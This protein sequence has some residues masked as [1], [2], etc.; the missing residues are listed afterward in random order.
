MFF[1]FLEHAGTPHEGHIPHSGRYPWMSGEKW[2]KRPG[3]WVKN[4][5]AQE[6]YFREHP[7][8]LQDEK[9]QKNYGI[10][11]EDSVEVATAKLMNMKTD[12]YRAYKS[13]RKQEQKLIDIPKAVEMQAK[14]ASVADIAKELDLP[15]STVKTYLKPGALAAASPTYTIANGLLQELEKRKYL[16]VGLGVERQLGISKEQLHKALLMLQDDGYNWFTEENDNAIL[17]KQAQNPSKKTTFSVLTG[18]DVTKEELWE[19][20]EQISSPDGIRFEDYGSELV[21]RGPVESIDSDRVYIRYDEEGGTNKEGV[22]EIRPG[23]EDLSLGGRTYAQVRIAVDGTHYLKGMAVYGYD[24]PEGYDIVFNTN[25][26]EG[27]PALGPSGNTVLKLMSDDPNNPFGSNTTQWDYINSEGIKTQS[28]IEI[29]N[30]DKDWEKW[31]KSLPSQVLSK[32]PIDLAKRQLN[33]A[34]LKK[35]Q[36]FEE[37]MSINNPT[38]RKQL[39][40]EFA[41]SCDSD[42][43]ELKAAALPGQSTKVLLP[44]TSLK[45][46]EVYCP[47]YDQGTEVILIRFPHAGTFEIPTLR[48]NNDNEEAKTVLGTHPAHAIG[49][50]TAVTSVL[51]GADFDGDT[52]LIIPTANQ[53]IRTTPPLEGLKNFDP[54]AKYKKTADQQKTGDGDGFIKGRTM[55]DITNLITDMT[56]MA[57]SKEGGLNENDLS[58]IERAVRHSMVVI[59]AEKHNLDWKQS[60]EDNKIAELKI[61]YQGGVRRGAA[62]LISRAGGEGSIDEREEITQLWKMT[63]EEK[64]RWYNGEKIYRKTGKMHVV[65]DADGN[66]KLD[67]YG[68][69]KMEKNKTRGDKLAL[70]TDAYELASPYLMDTV[71]A[72]HSNSLKALAN[73]ARKEERSIKTPKMN[74]EAAKVYAAEVESLEAKLD[75]AILNAP[76][77]RQAQAIANK[78]VADAIK[79]DPTLARKNDKDAA[80]RLSKLRA[81]EIEKARAATHAKRNPLDLT[82]KEWNAIEAGALTDNK[83]KGIM[84]YAKPGIIKKYASGKTSV[85]LNDAKAARA[86]ALLNSGWSQKQVADELGVSISTL[87]KELN[88][89]NGLGGD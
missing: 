89:F 54:R 1:S 71:Y 30:E 40:A 7:E 13:L 57:A 2:N 88:N 33:L 46:N 44:V 55:G 25:K 87:R 41:D 34:Y 84:R 53:H 36:E 43:V 5:L 83:V 8:A 28:P 65:K 29:V 47:D 38:V 79:K 45:D 49:V 59:D 31:K 4:A 85:A 27:T 56:M 60:F 10:K 77:E 50:N 78:K 69:V 37:I 17:V 18:P 23:V 61:K 75:D 80:D 16:D 48:V 19:N 22:I 64:E 32:Q 26:H 82:E 24:M 81:R 14:G 3:E 72:E 66:P 58:E 42:S 35:E 63:D 39:L 51:S 12:D 11:P 20:R 86:R 62:T 52:V 6:K 68:N 21:K 74:A 76:R 70:V 15:W 73:R 9:L 67:R